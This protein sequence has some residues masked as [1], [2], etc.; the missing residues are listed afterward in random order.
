MQFAISLARLSW[1]RAFCSVLSRGTFGSVCLATVISL[2]ASNAFAQIGVGQCEWQCNG[3]GWVIVACDSSAGASCESCQYPSGYQCDASMTGV[4]QQFPINMG[5]GCGSCTYTYNADYSGWYLQTSSCTGGGTCASFM[6]YGAS[7]VPCSCPQTACTGSCDYVAIAVGN[8]QYN[9]QL[10]NNGC[11]GSSPCG[12]PTSPV[13]ANCPSQQSD[14]LSVACNTGN[15]TCTP[16]SQPPAC[17]GPCVWQWNQTGGC[18]GS[19]TWYA[20]GSSPQCGTVQMTWYGSYWQVSG[21]LCGDGCYAIPPSYS[22]TAM[23]ETVNVQC[24]AGSSTLSW[25]L[26][27]NNCSS[28]CTP[29]QPLYAPT[30]E[31]QSA[32]GGCN[33]SGTV[34]GSWVKLSGTCAA[35]CSCAPPTADGT[36]NGQ[37]ANTDCTQSTTTATCQCSQSFT[38]SINTARSKFQSILPA[39]GFVSGGQWIAPTIT[40]PH[41]FDSG[42]WTL[43]MSLDPSTW[44][45]LSAAGATVRVFFRSLSL[46]WFLWGMAHRVID[47]FRRF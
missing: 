25:A 31:G 17:G 29:T 26:T 20:S 6:S 11:T 43:S 1:L 44:G 34:S 35:S 19:S 21:G 5:T 40:I 23:G 37:Q 38:D 30:S 28:G 32:S 33:G 3:T 8:G 47:C 4:T 42:N 14:T 15:G 45:G 46:V 39:L 2:L 9:W 18:T 12:C 22:G 16:V 10:N 41:G 27:S 13:G 36:T 7:S 24:T